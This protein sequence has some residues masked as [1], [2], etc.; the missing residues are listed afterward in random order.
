MFAVAMRGGYGDS[1]VQI[2]LW[3]L[4]EQAFAA[5]GLNMEP[6]IRD[7]GE[8]R[9]KVFALAEQAWYCPFIAEYSGQLG[10]SGSLGGQ[11]TVRRVAGVFVFCTI[12]SQ[13]SVLE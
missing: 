2:S 4:D 12:S 5:C 7:D 13:K 8:G 9:A 3:L 10:T 6:N 1:K 11:T